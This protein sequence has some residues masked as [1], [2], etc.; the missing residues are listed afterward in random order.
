MKEKIGQLAKMLEKIL[1]TAKEIEKQDTAMSD[2]DGGAAAAA[3]GDGAAAAAD[4]DGK[5]NA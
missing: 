2:A 1:A 5:P 4:D 3:S